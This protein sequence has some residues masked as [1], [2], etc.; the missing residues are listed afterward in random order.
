VTIL[1]LT[2]TVTVQYICLVLQGDNGAALVY[3]SSDGI[4]TQVGVVSFG[5]AAGCTLGYPVV[6][7]RVTSF[8]S[9]ISSNTGLRI[10]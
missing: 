1:T 6:F 5:S 3:M 4:Y 9:W 10:D 8:L 7:T 2:N